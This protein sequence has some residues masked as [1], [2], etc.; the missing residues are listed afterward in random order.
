MFLSNEEFARLFKSDRKVLC[1]LKATRLQRLRD[2][3]IE[4]AQ[5]LACQGGKCLV[6]NK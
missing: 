3:G 5:I 2:L 4:N 6:S 1:V